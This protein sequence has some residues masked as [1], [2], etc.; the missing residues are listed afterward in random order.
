MK[1]ALRI[2]LFFVAISVLTSLFTLNSS[3]AAVIPSDYMIAGNLGDTWTYANL[4]STQFT[5]T[6]SEVVTGPNT[7]LFERGNNN[8][9]MVYDLTNDVLTIHEWNKTPIDPTWGVVFSEIELGQ[10]VTLN[11]D[12]TDPG[13]FLLWDIPSITVQAGTYNDLLALVWLDADFGA[14]TANTLLGLNSLITAG[15]TDIDFFARD[16]GQLKFQGIEAATG[17]SDGEGFELVSTSVVPIPATLPLF[18]SGIFGLV[19]LGKNKQRILRS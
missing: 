17:L 6:L 1:R 18:F 15:V 11:D 5:W 2:R 7:G 4:E 8:S 12:P 13:M 9:G 19:L 16:I 3:A 14:N 10:V